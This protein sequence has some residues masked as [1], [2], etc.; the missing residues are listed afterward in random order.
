MSLD[1]DKEHNYQ[2]V[3]D[4]LVTK[5][6]S[7]VMLLSKELGYGSSWGLICPCQ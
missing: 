2:E 7:R 6:V 3:L 5:S 1:R 4:R